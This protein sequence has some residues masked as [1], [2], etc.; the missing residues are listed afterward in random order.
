MLARMARPYLRHTAHIDGDFVVFLIGVR[1][2]QPWR[3]WTIVPVSR[4][5][6]AMVNELTAHPELG[7]LGV[8]QWVGRTTIHVQYWRSRDHLMAYARATDRVHLPAWRR[9]N[10]VTARS[11]AIGIWHE[12]YCVRAGEFECVYGNMPPFGLARATERVPVAGRAETARGR[13]GV[14]DGSDAPPL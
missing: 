14:T 11:N 5:M 8:E 12:T 13:L 1:L 7:C 6:G 9:F 10:Q 3:F 4:A 2:I